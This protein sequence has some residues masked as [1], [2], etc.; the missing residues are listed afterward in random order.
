MPL[1]NIAGKY[2]F[3]K[4]W[5]KADEALGGILPGGGV[6]IKSEILNKLDPN[7]NLAYRYMTGMGTEDLELSD[8]FKKG[9]VDLAIT[10]GPQITYLDT[11]KTE[12]VNQTPGEIFPGE[13]RAVNSYRGAGTLAPY[14]D[15]LGAP[16]G[17]ARPLDRE[18]EA[19]PYRYSL[20]RYNVTGKPDSY[21]VS[22]TYDFIN[23]FENPDLMTP[24]RKPLKALGA[25]VMGFMDPSSFV[26][27]YLYARDTPPTPIPIEF[28]VPRN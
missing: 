22:D 12:N 8:K 28:D 18:S 16:F 1:F 15:T 11:G 20:G 2:I 17:G 13:T 4:L 21:T 26:R 9:A 19:A 23:E 24:G 5:S 14:I 10:K 6:P 27:A 7:V 25:T 3:K